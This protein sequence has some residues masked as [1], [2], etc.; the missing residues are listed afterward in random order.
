MEFLEK[1]PTDI[2]VYAAIAGV[3]LLWLR[4]VLG[5][6]NN[7]GRQRP[8]PF[9]VPQGGAM[10]Q[11]GQG[12]AA[13]PSANTGTPVD[14]ALVQIAL[15]DRG[16]D[17]NR[18]LETAKETFSSV[19]TA[20]ADGDRVKLKEMLTESVYA[21]FD[22]AIAV[23]EAAGH[24]AMTEVLMIRDADMIDAKLDGRMASITLRIKADESYALTDATG[25]TI[26]GDSERV[27]TMTDVWT[28]TRDVK[29]KGSPWLV[30][31]TRDDVKEKDA[32]VLPEAGI[33][34]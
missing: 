29:T 19:V 2:L 22:K 31:Q 13:A 28:F 15:A 25:K 8:N 1:I 9:I 3:L 12:A 23:R 32:P 27:V 17:T 7:E 24:K 4:S 21:G 11:A 16:F 30:S 18:F 20:F 34:V 10:T 5:T 14:A 33:T 26:A 6:R